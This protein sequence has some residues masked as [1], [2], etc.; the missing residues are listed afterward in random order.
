MANLK[1]IN[2]KTAGIDIG[3]EKIF[4]SVEDENVENFGTYTESYIEAVKY[5]QKKQVESAAM[6]ATGVYWVTFYDLMVNAGLDVYVVNAA[7]AKNVPG[8]K[9]DVQDCQWIQQLHSYGLLRKCFIPEEKIRQLRTYM[10]LREDHIQTG[11]MHVQHIQKAFILM[12]IKLHNVITQVQG[13]SGRKIIEAIL[14]GE[15]DAKKLVEFCETSILKNKREEVIKSLQGN[16]KDEHLFAL[17]QAYDGWLFYQSKI[18]ECD[19]KIDKILNEMTKGKVIPKNISKAKKITHNKPNIEKLHEKLMT[20]TEGKDGTRLPGF[21]D[22][23]L[24]KLL[25]EV[26]T[27]LS[28]WQTPKHFTSWLG[29]SPGKNDS[30]KT[31]KRNK[32]KIHT[33]AGQIFKESAQTLLKSKYIGLGTFARRIKAKRGPSIAIK[34][35]ARKLAVMFYNIM[36]K[37]IEYVEQG[38]K[39]YEEKYKE[40]L[41]KSLNKRAIQFNLKLVSL[42]DDY[43]MVH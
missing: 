19:Q 20:V 23:S 9:T 42:T 13:A 38:I 33:K 43:S 11:A 1:K 4:I 18:K 10:R 37:G 40:S 34:A 31:K 26:G 7:D 12:N 24:M 2:K 22:Y 29:L 3:S 28:K 21:T 6:E 27:D 41:I 15:R 8:R 5:L 25:A 14:K 36:T 30:G 35:T 39:K 32:K 17:K 16:Y